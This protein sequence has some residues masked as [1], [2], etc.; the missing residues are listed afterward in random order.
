MIQ[1]IWHDGCLRELSLL[2]AIVPDMVT[3][4]GGSLRDEGLDE[5]RGETKKT[6]PPRDLNQYEPPMKP[7]NERMRPMPRGQGVYGEDR[8]YAQE[9]RYGPSQTTA[10]PEPTMGPARDQWGEPYYEPYPQ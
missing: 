8:Y 4:A 9:G 5:P 10:Y 1:F 6:P 2:E 7:Y 3:A